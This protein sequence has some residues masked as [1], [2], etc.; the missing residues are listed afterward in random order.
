MVT[1]NKNI[2]IDK[3]DIFKDDL[4]GREETVVN[5]SKMI[6]SHN[7][8]FVL[9]INGKWGS[10]KTNF[11][12][13]W[14]AYL[15]EKHKLKSIYFSAWEDDFSKEPFISIL[16]EIN[17]YLKD[18]NPSDEIED[19]FTNVKKI[20]SKIIR[21][22][23]PT[24]VK[25]LTAGIIDIEKDFEKIISSI[26]ENSALELIEN[27]SKH[28]NE[29]VEFKRIL[30][31]IVIELNNNLPLIIFIDELDRCR[32]TYAIELLERIKHVFGIEKVIFVLSTDKVQLS[33]SIKSLYG[34]IDT[35]NY[36]RRFIDLEFNLPN[37]SNLD[38][39][40]TLLSSKYNA[41]NGLEN[42]NL[43]HTRFGETVEMIL[44]DLYPILD[45]SLRQ[46]EELYRQLRIICYSSHN[47]FNLSFLYILPVLLS[48]KVYSNKLYRE[49]I[50]F[51]DKNEEILRIILSD[52]SKFRNVE[53]SYLIESVI[54]YT[55]ETDEKELEF[56]SS[57]EKELA[58]EKE[59][60][61]I[62]RLEFL[63]RCSHERTNKDISYSEEI[64]NAIKKVEFLD[65]FS[66]S[67]D[68]F[69]DYIQSDEREESSL[70]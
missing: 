1:I 48:L 10:G 65:N 26:A 68:C 9:N 66:F 67:D 29:I 28:K 36:L 21:K 22:S 46:I 12:K 30:S 51:K 2:V 5:L 64:R 15:E 57:L 38:K 20:A 18:L 52:T 58:K 59:L 42:E 34:D 54:R 56:I 55:V 16:G 43:E 23:F 40:F 27:Y 69:E 19:K 3:N 4:V 13:Y 8:S 70:F 6:L 14:Q 41:I 47:S 44:K 61:S 35:E 49:L 33:Q 62:H 50:S 37:I 11:V 31:E 45:L 63:L 39:Y 25:G 17:A 53:T 32:P 24:A 7:D 60:E